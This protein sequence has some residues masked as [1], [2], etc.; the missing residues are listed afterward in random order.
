MNDLIFRVEKEEGVTVL[1]LMLDSVT[2]DENEELKKVFTDL[3]DKGTKDI[4]LDLSE[5]SFMSSIVL[6]SLVFMLKRIKEAAGNLVL[7][8]VKDKV[9]EVLNITNLNKVFTIYQNRQEAIN[10]LKK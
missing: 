3:L 8:G 5:T 6:A 4:I 2:M 9:E 10:K 7:S 1:T